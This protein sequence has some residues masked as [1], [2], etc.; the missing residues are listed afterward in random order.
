MVVIIGV[1]IQG[2][3]CAY[4]LA[5][6]GITDVVVVEKEFIGAGSS[7]RSASMVMLQMENEDK[8]KL[9]QYSYSCYM[10]FKKEIGVDPEFKKIGSLSL[11][12]N[13]VKEEALIQ[14]KTRQRLG[15]RTEI[16]TRAE[17]S[18]IVPFV[19]VS[20]IVGSTRS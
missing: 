12:P 14:A 7:S 8:I 2:L 17:V 6:L 9:S 15:V 16:Y 19:N 1:G 18:K 3:S 13:S 5:E 11:V 4:S 10:R 20:D